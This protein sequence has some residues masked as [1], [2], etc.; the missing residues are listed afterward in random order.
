MFEIISIIYLNFVVECPHVPSSIIT[1]INPSILKGIKN[2]IEK[3]K[4]SD[5]L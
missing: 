3:P 1:L 2:I 4:L 5:Y